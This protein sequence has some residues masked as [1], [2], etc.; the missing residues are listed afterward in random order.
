MVASFY[1]T[2]TEP[3]VANQQPTNS[4]GTA[5]APLSSSGLAARLHKHEQLASNLVEQNHDVIVYLPPM[6]EAEPGRRFPV[7][8]M[9]DGQN[10]FDPAIS[11][12]K[13]NYWRMGETRTR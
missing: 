9:Q 4:P 6:Y 12:I 13:G 1:R 7:L 11:F 10:L 2:R 5:Q 8:Y 3:A